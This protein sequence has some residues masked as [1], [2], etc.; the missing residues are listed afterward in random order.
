MRLLPSFI[1]VAAALVS[2]CGND[3]DLKGFDTAGIPDSYGPGVPIPSEAG[4]EFGLQ[5][6]GVDDFIASDEWI[7]DPWNFDANPAITVDAWVRPDSVGDMHIVDHFFWYELR[8]WAVGLVGGAPA[9]KVYDGAIFTCAADSPIATGQWSFVSATLD[10]NHVAVF[11][12][13]ELRAECDAPAPPA[14]AE[15]AQVIIGFGFEPSLPFHGVI[16]EVRVSSSVRYDSTFTRPAARFEPDALTIGLWH[17][18]EDQ[19]DPGAAGPSMH[20]GQPG[21]EYL[22][23]SRVELPPISER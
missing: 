5:F 11:V 12:D 9:L 22:D 18:D 17:L 19:Q 23:P 3:S 1:C 6:D 13:G 14:E 2:G 20:F 16:D 8:G 10:S 4:Q 21:P 15:L 7:G